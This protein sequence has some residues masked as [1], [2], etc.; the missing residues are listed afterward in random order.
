VQ[1]LI[2]PIKGS[3]AQNETYCL[4]EENFVKT[5]KKPAQ[6]QRTDLLIY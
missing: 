3:I 4:K 2:A 6:G 1:T 5:G